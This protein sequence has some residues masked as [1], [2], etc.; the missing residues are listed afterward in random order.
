MSKIT[1]SGSLVA[2]LAAASAQGKTASAVSGDGKPPRAAE[3]PPVAVDAPEVTGDRLTQQAEAS[4]ALQ[5]AAQ[6]DYGELPFDGAA[7]SATLAPAS[8]ARL[9]ELAEADSQLLAAIEEADRRGLLTQTDSLGVTLHERLQTFLKEDETAILELANGVFP[10]EMVPRHR[11]PAREDDPPASQPKLGGL[12]NG[13]ERREVATAVLNQIL[14]PGNIR[15]MGDNDT[16]VAVNAQMLWAVSE[17]AEYFRVASALVDEGKVSFKRKSR[18]EDGAKEKLKLNVD[19]GLDGKKNS[20]YFNAQ[21]L[22]ANG[23]VN[24]AMQTALTAFSTGK[25][26]AQSDERKSGKGPKQS[27]DGLSRVEATQL[28]RKLTGS[29]PVFATQDPQALASSQAL[30]GAQADG[31]EPDGYFHSVQTGVAKLQRRLETDRRASVAIRSPEGS[32]AYAHL[33]N[34]LGISDTEVRF[35]DGLGEHVLAREEFEALMDLDPGRMAEGGIGGWVG[36]S[37]YA[38]SSGGRRTY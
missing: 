8:K 7:S 20:K 18:N 30:V 15:Q 3:Q 6:A 36:L 34:V 10:G 12:L 21:G 24:A 22:D 11:E 2:K 27:N 14:V 4:T 25:Y 5:A 38:Y 16:C 33:V 35:L 29:T 31:T 9:L 37:S 23:L 19:K 32:Q 13:A 1:S 17:P 28:L 26:F